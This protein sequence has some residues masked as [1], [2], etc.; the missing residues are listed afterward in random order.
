MNKLPLTIIIAIPL[1]VLAVSGCIQSGEVKP[2]EILIKQ[3]SFVKIDYTGKFTDG[4][5]FDTSREGIAK[6]TSIN[7]SATFTLRDAYEPLN[8]YMGN[9][10]VPQEKSDYI[11]VIKG[12]EKGLLGMKVGEAKVIIIEPKDG[13]G[14]SQSELIR[15]I[16]RTETVPVFENMTIQTFVDN[17]QTA[18]VVYKSIKHYF[19]GWNATIYNVDENK[20]IV[21]V[22]NVPD[23]N[24]DLFVYPWKTI[25]TS[26]S[27][28][29]GQIQVRHQPDANTISKTI[30]YTTFLQYHPSF[31]D[32][33]ALQE[34][35][36]QAQQSNP[37][38]GTIA[39]TDNSIQ[40]DFNMEVTGK[41][42]IFDVTVLEIT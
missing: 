3:G 32:I 7:K 39:Y 35:Y 6:D 12:M 38:P 10:P 14:L 4:R 13:Y 11:T 34:K 36:G 16:N 18:P 23:N 31:S 5:V 2:T 40:I 37:N 19:W 22:R 27:D 1:L 25:V 29:T 24:E 15:A 41:T 30:P 33:P 17:Y 26:V 20:N 21:V 42:L 8:V 28:T 9:P